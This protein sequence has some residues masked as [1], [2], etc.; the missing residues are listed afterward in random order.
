MRTNKRGITI[1]ITDEGKKIINEFIVDCI[2]AVIIA[3]IKKDT[4]NLIKID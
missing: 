3:A 2:G 1:T 4:P